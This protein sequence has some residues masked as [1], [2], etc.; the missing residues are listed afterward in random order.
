MSEQKRR[1]VVLAALAVAVALEI[2]L[3]TSNAADKPP[4]GLLAASVAEEVALV[5]PTNGSSRSVPSGPVA[6]LFPAPGGALFAPDL[7]NG[8]TTVIDLRSLTVREPIPGV[9]MP[10]FG[11]LTDRYLVLSRQLLVMSY[12]DRA[13]MNRFE[14]AFERPWQVEILADDTVLMVLER[15]PGDGEKTNLTAVSLNEGQ[16]VYRRPLDGDVRHF[17]LSPPLGLMALAQAASDQIIVVEPATLSPV[18]VYH[19]SGT[20]VDLVFVSGG[21]TLVTAVETAGG[22]GELL[23]W[24]LK[25]N[26][27]KG[28]ERKKEW[29]VPLSEAPVRLAP[30]PD[31]RHV[32]VALSSGELQVYELDTRTLVAAAELPEAPRDVAWCDPSIDGPPLP[33]WSDDDEPTLDLRR[34]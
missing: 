29:T 14:I 30:S 20:P 23:I 2:G 6:W 7:V 15:A 19:S 17:A 8:R 18:A 9:T 21:S 3:A 1:R 13:L 32:A 22:G 34:P 5:D 26:K 16:L 28:L 27:K 12:P 31:G 33:E 11:T 10:H 25:Q 4:I 24:K